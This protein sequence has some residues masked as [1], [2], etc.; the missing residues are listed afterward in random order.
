V[1]E[2]LCEHV[3]IV[4]TLGVL[5]CFHISEKIDKHSESTFPD[6]YRF[7][8]IPVLETTTVSNYIEANSIVLK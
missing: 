4:K 1:N 5:V 2:L 6:G 3:C 8:H 7:E